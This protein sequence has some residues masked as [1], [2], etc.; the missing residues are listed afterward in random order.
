MMRHLIRKRQAVG[1]VEGINRSVFFLKLRECPVE[2]TLVE[3]CDAQPPEGMGG[4]DLHTSSFG[5]GMH[6]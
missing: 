2:D 3:I 6:W 1:R 4:S 5:A